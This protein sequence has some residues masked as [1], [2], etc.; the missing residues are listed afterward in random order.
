MKRV[1]LSLLVF[2]FA[3]SV[4]AQNYI[5]QLDEIEM[6]GTWEVVSVS[7]QFKGFDYEYRD[8]IPVSFTFADGNYTSINYSDNTWFFSGYMIT[9]ASTGKYFLHMTA[10]AN[11]SSANFWIYEFDNGNMTLKSYDNMGEIKL[12]KQNS[13]NI[14]SVQTE[15]NSNS[16]IYSVNGMELSEPVKGINI[17]NGKKF[18]KK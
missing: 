11:G 12:V 13:T 4:K 8:K 3:F 2:V 18:I 5:W 10:R 9:T 15:Q 17:Q 6:Q 14:N 16:K 7:G 1:F